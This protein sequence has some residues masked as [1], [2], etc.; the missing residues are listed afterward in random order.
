M[1][2]S[3]KCCFTNHELNYKE[4]NN[5]CKSNQY[6]CDNRVQ[7]HDYLNTNFKTY[8]ISYQISHANETEKVVVYTSREPRVKDLLCEIEK[9]YNIPIENQRLVYRGI[10]LHHHPEKK[11]DTLPIFPMSVLKLS[12]TRKNYQSS[13]I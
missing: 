6:Y 1:D 11:L 13:F 7:P 8:S 4:E 10:L 2:E 3:S 5:F 9:T 12:G